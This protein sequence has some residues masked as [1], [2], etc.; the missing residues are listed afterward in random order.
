MG[1]LL[2][3]LVRRDFVGL[4]HRLAETGLPEEAAALRKV[5]EGVSRDMKAGK[6]PSLDPSLATLVKLNDEGLLEPYVLLTR[7]D[8]GIARDYATYRKGHRDKLRSYMDEY[9]VPKD[10]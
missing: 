3:E 5:A 4:E 8:A 2:E 6:I 7:A 1:E 9:V 10:Q